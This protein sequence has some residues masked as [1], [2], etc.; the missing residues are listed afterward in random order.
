M[1]IYQYLFNYHLHGTFG[2]LVE[3]GVDEEDEEHYG[4]EHG[5][6]SDQYRVEDS[7]GNEGFYIR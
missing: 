7:E 3:Q 6:D 4:S 1:I 5:Y 2:V